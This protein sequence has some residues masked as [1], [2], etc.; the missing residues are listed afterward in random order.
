MTWA[1]GAIGGVVVPSPVYS[2]PPS[3]AGVAQVGQQLILTH[4]VAS[5]SPTYTFSLQRP[6]L[7]LIS[8]TSP[9]TVVTADL[10]LVLTLTDTATSGGQTAT[11]SVSTA[12]VTGNLVSRITLL[13]QAIT[14]KFNALAPKLIP[15]GGSTGQQLVKTSA[16]NYATGWA[17]PKLSG[18]AVITPL[19]LGGVYEWI[20]T[21]TA[22]GL[23]PGN[24]VW[25]DIVGV[26]DT[27]ENEPEMLAGTGITGICTANDTLTVKATFTDPVSGP[28]SLIYGVV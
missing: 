24:S 15:A 28:I 17:S 14:A 10:G 11:S 12:A 22:V 26:D 8:T 1:A 21:V 19:D 16:F 20:E 3:I 25:V 6:D 23:V 4:G 2:T 13:T 27:F 9:Y 18:T 5:Q 7:T